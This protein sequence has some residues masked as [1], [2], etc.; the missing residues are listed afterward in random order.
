MRC[1]SCA[2]T[3]CSNRPA[4]SAASA[5][6]P[7]GLTLAAAAAL[8]SLA[9]TCA[10]LLHSRAAAAELRTADDT[11]PAAPRTPQVPAGVTAGVAVFD[12]QT[13]TFTEQLN[14]SAT[15]RSASP[16]PQETA[17]SSRAMAAVSPTVSP[18]AD[19]VH[20]T[21]GN[22]VECTSGNLCA[23]SPAPARRHHHSADTGASR[24]RGRWE[25]RG[26]RRRCRRGKPWNRTKEPWVVA[27]CLA[28]PVRSAL[29]DSRRGCAG[30]AG[31]RRLVR[32]GGCD[33]ARYG[34]ARRSGGDGAGH[35]RPRHS[36][37]TRGDGR[38]AG[39]ATVRG[40]RRRAAARRPGGAC[41]A[42][43]RGVRDGR[44]RP[45]GTA[46]FAPPHSGAPG[47]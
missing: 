33:R 11:Q 2:T 42:T 9:F 41:G 6:G 13:G 4:A 14:A 39:W 20:T 5:A 23:R 3:G 7:F 38:R 34:R 44:Q 15:F 17:A 29:S 30:G 28:G 31:M 16:A 47:R 21:S 27:A 22:P 26:G 46:P 32:R 36:V 43:A 10:A 8:L 40:R 19:Y 45:L 35:E 1:G 37:R 18:A 24:S 25:R 12:R